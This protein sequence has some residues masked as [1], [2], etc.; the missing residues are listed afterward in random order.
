M[1]FN[2][3]VHNNNIF[4]QLNLKWIKNLNVMNEQNKN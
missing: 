2:N 1:F 3:I 4:R